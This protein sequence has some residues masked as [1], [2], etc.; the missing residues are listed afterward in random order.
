MDSSLNA[1]AKFA[2]PTS[3]FQPGTSSCPSSLSNAPFAV[4][5]VDGA[6]LGVGERCCLSS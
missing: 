2:K 6:G 3:T 4:V 5:D 1:R